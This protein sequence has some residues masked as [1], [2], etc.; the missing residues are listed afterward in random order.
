WVGRGGRGAAR[1]LAPGPGPVGAAGSRV[2]DGP[3]GR[4]HSAALRVAARGDGRRHRVVG[5]SRGRRLGPGLGRYQRN[6]SL[7]GGRERLDLSHTGHF[8]DLRAGDLGAGL[9]DRP[10]LA[11]GFRDHSGLRLSD[12]RSAASG[13]RSHA[14]G[15]ITADRRG[16]EPAALR[17][18]KMSTLTGRPLALGA[19]VLFV[20]SSAFP[21]V[22]GL[23]EDTASF[24]RWWGVADVAIAFVLAM[25]A[26]VL[27]G[28]WDRR[29]DR[30]AD[31]LNLR[32]DHVH[33]PG[34]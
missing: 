5:A 8:R 20:V 13:R 26:F 23:A 4:L 9:R 16:R 17:R 11:H 32:S 15:L 28:L 1:S 3:H 19:A 6:D 10:P 30:S 34:I 24:P 22:A 31:E 18:A 12:D 27:A 25:L 7:P 29:V 2:R 21:V 33:V 14:A